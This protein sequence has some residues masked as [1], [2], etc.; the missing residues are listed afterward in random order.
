M[1]TLLFWILILGVLAYGV[2]ALPIPDPFK[3]AAYC[4]LVIFLIVVAF[5]ALGLVHS[6]LLR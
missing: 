4:I 3:T 2:S 6:P 5:E 1:L